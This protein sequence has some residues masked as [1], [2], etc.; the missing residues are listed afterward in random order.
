LDEATK[1]LVK[2]GEDIGAQTSRVGDSVTAVVISP[3]RF[4]GARFAGV[5]DQVSSEDGGSLRFT[6]NALDH[7]AD[8]YR[9]ASR[10]LGF[11][12]SKG[13]PLVDEQGVTVQVADG[14]LVSASPGWRLDEGS[15]VQLQVE[16]AGN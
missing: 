11:V 14:V 16:P 4:L 5:V 12:N 7:R 13:Q 9:V 10:V 8:R 15:E 2:L 1:F 6:F 3:E